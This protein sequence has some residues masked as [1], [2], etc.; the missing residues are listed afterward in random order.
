ML[1]WK[2]H[3]VEFDPNSVKQAQNIGLKIKIGSLEDAN[4]PDNQFDLITMNHVI[5]HLPN[6]VETLKECLR[7]L[8]PGGKLMMVTPNINAYG[9]TKF[10]SA[11][12][13]L[14]VPRHL[15]IFS[16]KSLSEAIRR[17]G[18]GIL[19][20]K[21]LSRSAF[22]MYIHSLEIQNKLGRKEEFNPKKYFSKARSFKREEDKLM[23]SEDCGEELYILVE[24]S[25]KEG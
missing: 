20:I 9:H 22:Y 1:G 10:K 24:K 6:P 17:A 21:T 18:F 19:N 7:V 4:Y 14:E 25:Q 23:K 15:N 3:G 12:R 5:E 16:V 13:G 11:W 8:K 2:G